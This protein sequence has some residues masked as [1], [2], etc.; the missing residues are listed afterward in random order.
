[1]GKVIVD[2]RQ[3]ARLICVDSWCHLFCRSQVV[4]SG[5]GS[6]GAGHLHKRSSL[7]YVL[8]SGRWMGGQRPYLMSAF[9]QLPSA[10]NNPFARA[11]YLGVV[12]SEPLHSYATNFT[13]VHLEHH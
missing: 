2:K 3:L 13:F 11:V 5:S 8:L 10:Q 6:R 9:S 7:I 12:Y 4:I 1:M